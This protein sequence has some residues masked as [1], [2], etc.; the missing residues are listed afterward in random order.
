MHEGQIDLLPGER[1]IWAGHPVRR[2][3]F[4]PGDYFNVPFGLLWLGGVTVFFF[5]HHETAFLVI[6]WSV[7][8]VAGVFHLAGRP[9]I[10]YLRL[11]S[12]TYAVTD[13]RV[14]ATSSLVRRKDE[15]A[16]L[17]ELDDPVVTPGPGKT[18]TITFGRL[19][20]LAWAS[21]N[22]GTGHGK[23][24]QAPV[25]LVGV[26]EVGKVREKLA[27]AVEEARQ[28]N[29]PPEVHAVGE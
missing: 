29:K 15:S 3:L 18:G 21:A 8:T 14:L 5:H 26:S 10:R 2:P 25:I 24:R 27:K 19:G 6:A 28:R 9:L 20:V 4:N 17:A 1:V 11:A 23:G 12:T 16:S 13:G 22:Y 7:L